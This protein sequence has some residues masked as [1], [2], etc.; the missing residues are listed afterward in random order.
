MKAK[1]RSLLCSFYGCTHRWV[2]NTDRPRCSQHQP[3]KS[4]V[5][6]PTAPPVRHWQDTEKDV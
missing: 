4:P 5:K 2:T 3:N 6:V 1:A